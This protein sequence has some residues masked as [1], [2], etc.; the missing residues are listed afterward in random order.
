MFTT[1]RV[2]SGDPPTRP[3]E[4]QVRKI[5]SPTLLISA[6]T[7]EERDF[8]DLYDEAAAG[9][10]VEHWNLPGAHHTHAIHEHP[11]EYE[12]RVAS[13]FDRTLR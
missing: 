11:G 13:F 10:P 3:L 1:I 5:A 12:Q 4:D 9:G 7:T 8:N 6:G 2:L